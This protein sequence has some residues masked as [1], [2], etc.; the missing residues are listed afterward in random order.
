[1]N[2]TAMPTHQI[3]P[4]NRRDGGVLRFASIGIV[5]A[6]GEL[7]GFPRCDS[8]NLVIAA[9][10]GVKSSL[11]CKI[12]FFRP[13]FWFAEQVQNKFEDVF[14]IALQARP[15]NTGRIAASASLN[16]RRPDF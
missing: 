3:F 2:V 8:T 12:K 6:I 1:M 7:S 13:K 14:E 15:A 5:R 10:N 9:R 4:R 11:L 16:L